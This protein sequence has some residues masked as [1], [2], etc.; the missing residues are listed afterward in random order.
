[1]DITLLL[2]DFADLTHLVCYPQAMD[3]DLMEVDDASTSGKGKGES[4]LFLVLL[5]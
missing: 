5:R 2:L 3:A 1:M 4:S